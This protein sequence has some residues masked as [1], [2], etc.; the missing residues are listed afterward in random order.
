MVY[1]KACHLLVKLE[2]KAFWALKFLNFDQ[3]QYSMKRKV[4]INELDE[5]RLQTYE[6]SRI[7]KERVKRYHDSKILPKDFKIEQM[8][9]LF[10][11]RLRLFLGML[12][13]KWLGSF[14][15]KNVKP[16]H[17]I[18]LEDPIYKAIWTVNG[19][20]MKLYLVGDINQL[21]TTILCLNGNSNKQA[22]R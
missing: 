12:K 8:V 22:S 16:Y 2:H 1:G 4:K 3:H 13:L 20:Q 10:N 6:S 11:S 9:Q 17:A 18:E 21:T 19:Q 5:L 7:Y 15:I 14:Q